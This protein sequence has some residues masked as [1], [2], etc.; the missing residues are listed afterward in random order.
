MQQ[1]RYSLKSEYWPHNYLQVMIPLMP[2]SLF[3]QSWSS[4]IRSKHAQEEH[5]NLLKWRVV[6]MPVI[7][8]GRS[9]ESKSQNSN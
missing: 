8:N 7:V 9:G 1:E 3:C 2:E 4:S 6:S 5:I